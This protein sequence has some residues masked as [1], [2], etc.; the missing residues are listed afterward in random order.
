MEGYKLVAQV[1]EFYLDK[2]MLKQRGQIDMKGQIT[3][4]EVIKVLPEVKSGRFEVHLAFDTEKELKLQEGT[5]FG[6]KLFL[7]GKEKALLLPKGNFFQDTKG[8]WVYVVKNNKATR[9]NVEIGRENP[10]YYEVISGLEVGEEVIVS[11]YKDYLRV[12][13]L[14]IEE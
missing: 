12:E 14:N 3:N 13:H 9:R 1:D 7:S 10:A 5:T 6:V 11:S 4:V 8:E 2:I